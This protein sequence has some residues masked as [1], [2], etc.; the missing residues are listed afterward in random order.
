MTTVY[1]VMNSAGALW[2]PSPNV[3]PLIF[4]WLRIV[5]FSGCQMLGVLTNKLLAQARNPLLN[6]HNSPI[7][8]LDCIAIAP[9]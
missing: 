4:L 7:C 2:L 6:Q 3:F 1:R 8:E 9:I 5:I